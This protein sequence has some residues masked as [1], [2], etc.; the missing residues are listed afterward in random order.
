MHIFC[1]DFYISLY[2]E[3]ISYYLVKTPQYHF[4][5]TIKTDYDH[6]NNPFKYAISLDGKLQGCVNIK[7]YDKDIIIIEPC[8]QIDPK[9]AYIP[10]LSY[11]EKCSFDEALDKD[12]GTKYMIRTALYL[13][14]KIFPHV[15]KF[16][17]DDASHFNCDGIEV[18]LP[19]YNIDIH[20]KTWYEHH[21]NAYL[22]EP[23]NR[24]EYVEFIKS[25]SETKTVSFDV[26][27]SRFFQNN[28][29]HEYMKEIYDSTNTFH[30]LFLQLR[31]KNKNHFCEMTRLWLKD[32][33]DSFISSPSKMNKFHTWIIDAIDLGKNVRILD[34]VRQ[35]TIPA[36]NVIKGGAR[37]K[38]TI[39]R[40]YQ[41][42]LDEA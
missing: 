6:D 34:A 14:K 31:K 17:L 9:I 25:F 24:K 21:F 20:G 13:V 12:E 32:F 7:V 19:H 11:Q 1:H 33:V 41:D 30:E 10:V 36:F 35:E 5:L 23:E 42:W 16:V 39:I 38:H 18:S 8:F 2:I 15:Q 27:Y 28:P 3:D 40:T 26:L 29:W 4:Y 22:A 37:S